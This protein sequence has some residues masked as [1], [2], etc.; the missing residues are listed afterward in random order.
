MSFD[1]VCILTI[2]SLI[3]NICN[4]IKL[5][6]LENKISYMNGEIECLKRRKNYNNNDWFCADGERSESS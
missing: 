1:V 6:M 3:W 2:V 5:V 4:I